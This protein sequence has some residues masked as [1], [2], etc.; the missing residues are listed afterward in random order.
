MSELPPTATIAVLPRLLMKSSFSPAAVRADLMNANGP[1]TASDLQRQRDLE[2]RSLL[3][4]ACRQC[5]HGL[6]E[7]LQRSARDPRTDLTDARL[8]MRNTSVDDRHD[9]GIEYPA[10]IDAGGCP[11][12]V[13]R[14]QR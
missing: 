11:G 14:G 13:E 4:D 12:E 10:R 2:F 8:F 3:C 7:A 9:A 1:A 6:H 5:L